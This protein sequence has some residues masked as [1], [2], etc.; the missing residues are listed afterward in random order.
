MRRR[1]DKETGGNRTNKSISGDDKDI[2]YPYRIEAKSLTLFAGIVGLELVNQAGGS[3]SSRLL[4]E[5]P[6]S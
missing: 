3:H 1:G 5:P 4:A 6:G 2:P